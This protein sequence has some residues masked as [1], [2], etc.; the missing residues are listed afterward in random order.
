MPFQRANLDVRWTAATNSIP[1]T[2]WV[3]RTVP[4]KFSP[5][6]ISYLMKLGSFTDKDRTYVNN[7][8]NVDALLFVSQN[9]A[10]NLTRQLRVYS[11]DGVITYSDG[12]ANPRRATNLSVGVP[13]ENRILKLTRAILP[14]LG[15]GSSELMLKTNGQLR[16]HFMEDKTEYDVNHSYITNIDSRGVIF[17]RRLDGAEVMRNSCRIDL[18][19]HADI[20]KIDMT[21]PKLERDKSYPTATPEKIMEWIREGKAVQQGLPMNVFPID[22]PTVKSLTIKEVYLCYLGGDSYHPKEWIYPYV[23]LWGV[24]D[25]GNGNVDVEIDCPI[26]DE[27]KL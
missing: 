7:I 24:V 26:I 25:T 12:R 19:N 5:K 8:T 3:Y 10:P 9:T 17:T 15:I 27:T 13:P 6:V 14:K 4:M 11:L 20:A 2:I 22:W 1:K 23:A 21:W 16:V 18:G